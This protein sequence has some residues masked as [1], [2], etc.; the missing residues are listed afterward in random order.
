MDTK[1]ICL[2]CSTNLVTLVVEL[3]VGLITNW[4]PLEDQVPSGTDILLSSPT[5]YFFI[6]FCL[7]TEQVLASF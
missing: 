5:Y 6:I 7:V 3:G 1:T 4:W 2:A